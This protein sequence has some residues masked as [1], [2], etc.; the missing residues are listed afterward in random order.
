MF[1]ASDSTDGWQSCGKHRR[2][3]QFHSIGEMSE[4]PS[5]IMARWRRFCHIGSCLYFSNSC[6][7]YIIADLLLAIDFLCTCTPWLC[8]CYIL[9]Y[10]FCGVY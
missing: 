2:C 5:V 4:D 8:C 1:T 10:T 3:T 7:K 9:S 6:L